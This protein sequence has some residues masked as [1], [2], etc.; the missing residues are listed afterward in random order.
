MRLAPSEYFARQCWISFEVDETT[1]P[2]LAPVVGEDRV[3]WGSD[4]PHHDAT[5][6]GAV[7]ALRRTTAPM[8]EQARRMVLG[9]NAAALYRLPAL[10]TPA[11][12]P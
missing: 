5:F 11:P 10:G 8:T 12:A 9:A 4:Y 2:V 6:P 1:L 3:L 7:D